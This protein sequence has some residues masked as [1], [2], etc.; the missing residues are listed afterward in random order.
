VKWWQK[1]ETK[2]C[3][4]GIVARRHYNNGPPKPCEVF[5]LNESI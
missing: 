4:L 5:A 3:N 2:P 1:K